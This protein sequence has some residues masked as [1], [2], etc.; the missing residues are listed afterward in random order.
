L[1]SLEQRTCTTIGKSL[2]GIDRMRTIVRLEIG[3]PN[4]GNMLNDSDLVRKKSVFFFF[5]LFQSFVCSNLL[6][7]ICALFVASS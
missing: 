7:T 4:L 1:A 2:S 6:L 3:V 5:L